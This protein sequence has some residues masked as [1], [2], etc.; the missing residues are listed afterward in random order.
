[1]AA[2]EDAPHEHPSHCT[3]RAMRDKCWFHA[4]DCAGGAHV[5]GV[6]R[7]IADTLLNCRQT[8]TGTMAPRSRLGANDRPIEAVSATINVFVV[9]AVFV[10][11]GNERKATSL[12]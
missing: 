7:Q 6:A 8:T 12:E 2:S 9:L 10:L 11:L 3:R 5:V 4:G 1:M